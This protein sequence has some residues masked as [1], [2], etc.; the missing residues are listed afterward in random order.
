MVPAKNIVVTATNAMMAT[1][2]VIAHQA[3]WM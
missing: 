3:G 2:M 1:N